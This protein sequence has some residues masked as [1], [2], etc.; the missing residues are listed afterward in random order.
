MFKGNNNFVVGLFVSVSIAVFVGF[1]LWLTGRSGVEEMENYSMMFHR[2]VSGL[3]IGGPV[4]F[5][6][7]NIG[8]VTRMQLVRNENMNVRVDIEILETTPVDSGTFASLAF[9]GITGVAVINLSSDPGLHDPIVLAPGHEFPVIPV[10]DV[11]LAALLSSAPKIMNQM[12]DLLTQANQLLGE[13]NRA[14]IASTLENLQL[15][16]SSL[17]E[18]RET[19]ARLPSDLERTLAGIE[20]T[21]DRFQGILKDAEP[22]LSSIVGNIDLTS[23]NLAS[24]TA[25]LDNWMAENE[26]SLQYFVEEGLGE[27]P[28]LISSARQALRQLEKLLQ[29]MQD[30]PSQLIHRV[31][32]DALEIDP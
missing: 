32:E 16:V 15:L 26:A 9:Q 20:A 17:A 10:R 6:G 14:A 31:P 30:S 1:V 28:E 22:G 27:A 24:L 5:M 13:Q 3:S 23:E 25:R 12:D 8:T 4:N 2:D 19:I 11:G 29:E 21:V 7:V 18:S